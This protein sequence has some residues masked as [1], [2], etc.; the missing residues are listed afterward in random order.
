MHLLT[1]GFKSSPCGPR[2]ATKGHMHGDSDWKPNTLTAYAPA[3]HCRGTEV[4]TK[5]C[6]LAVNS[7]HHSMVIKIAG[8]HQWPVQSTNGLNFIRYLLSML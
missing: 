3:S 5:H 7:S 8:R 2:R 1:L 4:R 6:V